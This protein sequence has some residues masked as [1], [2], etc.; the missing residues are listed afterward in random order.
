MMNG[1]AAV[2]CFRTAATS[3]PSAAGS[4]T[5]TTG[6][7]SSEDGRVSHGGGRS[8]RLNTYVVPS[9]R[10][11]FFHNTNDSGYG[12]LANARAEICSML[13]GGS[14]SSI[15]VLKGTRVVIQAPF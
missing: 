9:S 14:S 1:D 12:N 2:A 10:S 11:V 8:A 13:Y 4:R 15:V 6:K 7:G 5:S 3:P